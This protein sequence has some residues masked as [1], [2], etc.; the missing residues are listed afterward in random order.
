MVFQPNIVPA[1]LAAIPEATPTSVLW[2]KPMEIRM[3]YN[4]YPFG[5]GSKL[6][7]L[8]MDGFPTKHDHF[9]GPLVP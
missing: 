9:C 8:K 2:E 4:G 3:G 1:R 7:N 5:Y 6:P